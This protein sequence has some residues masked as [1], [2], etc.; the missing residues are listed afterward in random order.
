MTVN[1][2]LK[3]AACWLLFICPFSN[4][5]AQNVGIGTLSPTALL[6]VAGGDARINGLAVGRGLGNIAS[7]VVV[8]DSALSS[9]VSGSDNTA[10]GNRALFK[11]TTGLANVAVGRLSLYNNSV[12][13]D[14]VAV[15]GQALFANDSGSINTAVGDWSLLNNVRGSY[16]TAVGGSSLKSNTTG[17]S[18]TAI[19]LSS[20]IYSNG[21]YNTAAGF[22]A[23]VTN[24]TGSYNT[25]IGAFAEATASNLANATA[26]GYNA[27]VSGSN[28]FVIGGTGADAVNVGIGVA[29][30]SE[31]LHVNG[32]VK[33]SNGSYSGITN[34][35]DAP[36]PAGGT[37]TIVFY[38][39]HFYG[40]NGSQWKQLDN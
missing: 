8:G 11:N 29:T 33:L 32:A 15:G 37:G 22:N 16:N 35:A 19:G 5:K 12:G 21:D 7:N 10:I 4:L 14:N 31:K 27:K 20:L 18:N 36:A 38:E 30:P 26:I 23:G 25:F 17:R 24:T 6:E 39:A 28:C 34:N 9:N 1:N 3:V 2:Y 13:I 40:W